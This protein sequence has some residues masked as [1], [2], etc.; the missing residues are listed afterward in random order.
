LRNLAR[1]FSG[2]PPRQQNAVVGR[3]RATPALNLI[4]QRRDLLGTLPGVAEHPSVMSM[5]LVPSYIR[6]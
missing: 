6:K 3:L 1:E 4:A 5:G 2:A